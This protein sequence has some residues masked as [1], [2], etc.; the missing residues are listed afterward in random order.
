MATG[1]VIRLIL[2]KFRIAKGI[3]KI[4]QINKIII[5]SFCYKTAL[6]MEVRRERMIMELIIGQLQVI[7][8][9]KIEILKKLKYH[10]KSLVIA[11]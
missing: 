8:I 4:H 2:M 6:I 11:K 1:K 10:L 9:F 7:L 5:K 3:S